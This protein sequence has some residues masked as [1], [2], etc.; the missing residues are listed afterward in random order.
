M[1]TVVK[2]VFTDCPLLQAKSGLQALPLAQSSKM[3]EPP[4]SAS[5]D[6]QALG[7]AL[8]L[9]AQVALLVKWK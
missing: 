8:S 3:G 1:F 2:G 4:A 6:W 9:S 5:T 7:E